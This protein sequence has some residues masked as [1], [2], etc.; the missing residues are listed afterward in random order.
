M[1]SKFIKITKAQHLKNYIVRL[2]F[3]DSTEQNVDFKPFLS[4]SAHPEIR[5]Y[6]KPKEFK[7][8][9]LD[10]GDLMWGDFDLV[11]PIMDLYKNEI[12]TAANSGAA[13]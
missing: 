13:F 11:F 10:N 8:F 9:H 6:L 3:S 12:S 5:K 7:K 2:T 1:K 4:G